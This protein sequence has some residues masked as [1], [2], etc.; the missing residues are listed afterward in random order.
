MAVGRTH[1][2]GRNQARP[3]NINHVDAYFI[4]IITTLH[5]KQSGN[6]DIAD[7]KAGS[8]EIGQS[9]LEQ[10]AGIMPEGFNLERYNQ[11]SGLIALNH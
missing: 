7:H 5:N 6:F 4:D 3:Q 8:Q 1:T 9:Q 11:I 10:I 2:S